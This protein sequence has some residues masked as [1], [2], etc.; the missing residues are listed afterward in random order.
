[1]NARD[2][3]GSAGGDARP[4]RVCPL[5]Y[6]HAPATFD[7]PEDLR[8][9]VLYVVGGLYGNAA[10]L[11][12]VE[13]L[14]AAERGGVRIAF[15][16]DFH[17]FDADPAV[18]AHIDRRVAAHAPSRGNVETELAS[19]DD[20]AGCGCAYPEEVGDAEVARSNAILA[21]LRATARSLAGACERLAALPMTR[22]AAVAGVRVGIAHG[23]AESLAGWSFAHD[24]LDAPGAAARVSAMLAAARVDVFATSHTCLPVCRTVGAGAVINNG[25]AGMPN[26]AGTRFGVVTRI[27]ASPAPA[28]LA[29]YGTRIRGAHV[30]ALRLAYD[31]DAFARDFLAAWPEGSP[32]HLSYWTRISHG[33]RHELDRARPRSL[34]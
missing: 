15:N 4:G 16:G 20:A 24:R 31:A 14:A 8:A 2:R 18:F 28:G 5:H 11:D 29:L 6:R 22:V 26:F 1:V 10:A 19:D 27:A 30:D 34:A 21:R 7:R 32:A 23:D 33:P 9:D 3:T 25:A 17:W 13:R 12:A